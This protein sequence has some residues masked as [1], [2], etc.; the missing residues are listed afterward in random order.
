MIV[1]IDIDDA[2]IWQHRYYHRK[3]FELFFFVVLR[4][5]PW[6]WLL[7]HVSTGAF[8][9]TRHK[10]PKQRSAAAAPAAVTAS[11]A[12]VTADIDVAAAAVYA[13]EFV[14]PKC[15]GSCSR[16]GTKFERNGLTFWNTLQ[17][18]GN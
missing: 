13:V 9:Q 4:I 17:N 7:Q 8:R 16:V 3:F 1:I 5:Q 12:A 11:F 18:Y 14:N 15:V 2:I 6:N 10:I